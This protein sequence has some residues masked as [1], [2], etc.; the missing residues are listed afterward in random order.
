MSPGLLAGL[1]L[2]PVPE[3]VQNRFLAWSMKRVMTEH[4]GLLDRLPPAATGTIIIAITDLQISLAL[5]LSPGSAELKIA[6]PEDNDM[7]I[8]GISGSLQDLIDLMEG[9]VDGDALFFSRKLAFS[10]DTEIVV[11]L[12]NALDGA[13]LN[14]ARMVPVPP[15]LS[16]LRPRL[17]EGLV[18]LHQTAL[19]DLE[20]I[21]TAATSHLDKA[22]RQ[23]KKKIKS[24][25][26]RVADLEQQVERSRR[27]MKA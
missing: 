6:L 14:I 15:F 1:A 19:R 18:N 22:S 2:R 27:R 21:R 4:P 17:A 7:A 23:H 26:D 16:A 13:D 25:E 10:G 8:A 12:R 11:A 3:A 5:E 20:L 9:R 24:L